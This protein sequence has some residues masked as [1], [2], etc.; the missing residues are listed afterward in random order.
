MYKKVTLKIRI[1]NEMYFFYTI[2]TLRFLY[3]N[4]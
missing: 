4:N 2:F 1:K 3:D